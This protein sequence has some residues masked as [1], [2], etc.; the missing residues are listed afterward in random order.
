MKILI[1]GAAGGIG[2]VL[3]KY[4][5]ELKYEIYMVDNFR[6][7]YVENIDYSWGE[8]Y[9]CDIN[10]PDFESIVGAIM[11]DSI[12]HL[13]AIT[14]L[15]E[16]EKNPLECFKVNVEGTHN[17]LVIAKK[18]GVKKVVFS[19]TSAV[20][21]NTMLDM[22]IGYKES[23]IIS[24]KLFYSLSKKMAEDICNS[25][26]VNYNM[27][28]TILRLF[29]VF[30]ANQDIFRKSPPL[31]NYL[32][33]EFSMDR[34]PV[35]HSNGYQMRDYIY[36]NDVVS[37][38]ESVLQDCGNHRSTYNVCSNEVLSVRDIVDIIKTEFGYTQQEIYRDSKQL[39]DDYPELFIGD[40]P[41]DKDVVSRETD[42]TSLGCNHKVRMRFGWCPSKSLKD[43][44]IE[45]C[46]SIIFKG[47]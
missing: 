26:I 44:I 13:A 5:H 32:M 39:W 36:V 4:L 22:K 6:N 28:I 2:S 8:F 7:G 33:R 40:N 17:V 35:L 27:D 9:K 1:T 20:Y 16:C 34:V 45:T 15:P 43:N 12:I 14:S 10:S 18:Y 38:I 11:P 29:N 24:P 3:S 30:G 19:S 37:L 23:D 42:K 46:K 25:Y 31:I 41:L 21:E 47:K